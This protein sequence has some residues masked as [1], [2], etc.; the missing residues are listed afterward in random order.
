[1]YTRIILIVLL[2]WIQRPVLLLVD[3]VMNIQN[4]CMTISFSKTLFLEV[5]SRMQ[6]LVLTCLTENGNPPSLNF[7]SWKY[8]CCYLALLLG[9]DLIHSVVGK[10]KEEIS[11][12]CSNRGSRTS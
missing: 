9:F 5:N 3:I 2:D 8:Y 6:S 7:V 12:R 10:E 11:A 1:M 4:S